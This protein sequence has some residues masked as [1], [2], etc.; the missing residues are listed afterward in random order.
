MTPMYVYQLMYISVNKNCRDNWV[1]NENTIYNM[2][3]YC[4]GISN[5]K[6]D[7]LHSNNLYI[8]GI[9]QRKLR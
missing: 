2:Y 6:L 3:I 7:S 9:I 5:S 1:F 4:C 8:K